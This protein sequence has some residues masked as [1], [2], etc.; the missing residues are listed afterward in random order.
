MAFHAAPKALPHGQT[1]PAAISPAQA[2]HWDAKPARF[3]WLPKVPRLLVLGKSGSGKS[4][5]VQNLILKHYRHAFERVVIC[6]PTVHKDVSTWGP[7]KKYVEDVL[8]VDG[9][10]EPFLFDDFD[11]VTLN[12]IIERHASVIQ[13]QKDKAKAGSTTRLFTMLMVF[14]DWADSP[15]VIGKRG[16][17]LLNRLF[18]SGRHDG[19]ATIILTQR[20]RALSTSLRANA[21]G[22]IVFRVS[23]QDEYQS[24]EDSVSALVDR[25]TFRAI[26]KTATREPYS[27][28]F[29]NSSARELNETFMVRFE[30]RITF[31]ESEESE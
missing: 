12:K 7:V 14:D 5:V 26:F 20:Y 27:F 24:V 13:K 21:T 17:S 6:S 4:I 19:V 28:L 10:K 15:E 2:I 9:T 3:P 11:P 22:L 1:H 25:K 18:I 29:I 16:N 30:H 8:G 31:P 23:D